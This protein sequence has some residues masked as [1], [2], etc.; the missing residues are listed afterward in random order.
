MAVDTAKLDFAYKYPFTKEAKDVIEQEGSAKLD[1][2]FLRAGRLRVQSAIDGT[3]GAFTRTND[4]ALRHTYLM[5]YVYARMLVSATSN[6]GAIESFA[7]AEAKRSGFALTEDD[8][9]TLFLVAKEMGIDIGGD[10]DEYKIRF[11]RFLAFSPRAGISLAK[12]GLEKGVVYADRKTVIRLVEEAMRLEAR[13]NLP[14]P[15]SALPKEVIAAAKEIKVPEVKMTGIVAN[16]GRYS[17]I[18]T[19]LA[20]PIADVRH[21]TVNLILAP[22][23]TNVRK[24]DEDKAAE[25]IMAYMEKCKTLNP[26]TKINQTYIKYQ[27]KYAKSKGMRPLSRDRAKELLGGILEFGGR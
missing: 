22:Y 2:R 21:R 17:W 4:M 23:L 9:T 10:G 11:D 18:E 15:R 14:I 20:T 27:C 26:D 7:M 12:Q 25:V 13:K 5:S 8:D 24:L 16:D 1:E 3:G 6:R 19:L